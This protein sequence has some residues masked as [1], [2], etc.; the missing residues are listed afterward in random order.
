MGEIRFIGSLFLIALFAI[1][2]VSFAIGFASDNDAA[3]SIA[4]DDSV[5][6]FVTVIGN[7]TDDFRSEHLNPASEGFTNST[8]ETSQET[9][10]TGGT[11]KGSYKTLINSMDTIMNG[12]RSKLFGGSPAFSIVITALVSFLIFVG[13]RYVWKTWK[14]GNPD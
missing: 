10:A 11:F 6:S 2:V 14:G 8:I 1:A 12:V 7:D 4:D 5:S 13:I 9:T 3:I